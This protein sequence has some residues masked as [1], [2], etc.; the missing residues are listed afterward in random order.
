MKNYKTTS[1]VH[2]QTL[3]CT[4]PRGT[5]V[6]IDEE[7]GV[8]TVNG[9]EHPIPPEVEI[10]LRHGILREMSVEE[11]AEPEPVQ[12][13][14]IEKHVRE[15]MPVIMEEDVS[16]EV[17][18]IAKQNT[19]LPASG[20]LEQE[21][22]RTIR[23]MKVYDKNEST[24]EE[25]KTQDSMKKQDERKTRADSLARAREAARAKREAQKQVSQENQ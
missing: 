18:R 10:M 25:L 19:T 9:E 16:R 12:P 7:N 11:A 4:Y 8:L 3:K 24:L 1:N 15:P 20:T 13:P 17:S 22:D 5:R 14:L 2:M 23:G 6:A 21:S